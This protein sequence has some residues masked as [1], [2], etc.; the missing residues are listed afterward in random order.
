MTLQDVIDDIHAL[1]EDLK[2]YERKYG[3]LSETF[4]ELYING[5]EPDN[6]DWV[7]DWSDWAGAYKLLI[8]RQEQYRNTV[9][10]FTKQPS[11]LDNLIAKTSRYEP[12]QLNS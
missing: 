6:D 5:T 10:A 1:Y 2:V 7:L 12:V 8:R 3:I 9:H 11:S 4:Y